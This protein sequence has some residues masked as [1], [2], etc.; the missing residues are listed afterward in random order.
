[1]SILRIPV[2]KGTT[3][4]RIALPR[5]EKVPQSGPRFIKLEEGWS[6]EFTKI[7]GGPGSVRVTRVGKLRGGY[8]IVTMEITDM[9][10]GFETVV[11][12]EELKKPKAD[13]TSETNEP[14]SE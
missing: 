3:Q 1:M 12:C 6:Q 14:E 13:E 7:Q 5:R 4:V 10:A 9:T 8:R 2:A 11:V